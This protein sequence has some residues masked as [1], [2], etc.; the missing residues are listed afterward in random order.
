ML[1]NYKCFNILTKKLSNKNISNIYNQNN[2]NVSIGYL[3]DAT[4]VKECAHSFCRSCILKH[5]H[6]WAKNANNCPKCN[7]QFKRD[8]EETFRSDNVLQEV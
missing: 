3:I 7:V 5:Y 6:S 8:A 2:E 4:A 1:K